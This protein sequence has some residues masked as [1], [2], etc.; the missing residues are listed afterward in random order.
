MRA[1]PKVCSFHA[2]GLRGAGARRCVLAV[3]ELE[4]PT[5]V[6]G[7]PRYIPGG[8]AYSFEPLM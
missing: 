3:Y 6:F 7:V 8:T 4:T 2:L 5:I 1:T